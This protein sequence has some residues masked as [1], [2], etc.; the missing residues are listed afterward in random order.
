MENRTNNSV[1]RRRLQEASRPQ[2][3]RKPQ[4]T[5]RLQEEVRPRARKQSQENN[6]MNTVDRQQVLERRAKLERRKIQ[7]E[8]RRKRRVIKRIIALIVFLLFVAGIIVAVKFITYK[9]PIE[10]GNKLLN[11]QQYEEAIVEFNRAVEKEELL[12]QA[13]LGIALCNWELGNIDQVNQYFDMAYA[14]GATKTSSNVNLFLS[15]ALEAEDY[16][17]ALEYIAESLA[18]GTNTEEEKQDLLKNEIACYEKLGDWENAKT[19]ITEYVALYPEDQEA[20]KEAEF[21]ST[22]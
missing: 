7:R 12:D 8:K 20:I 15:K 17:K 1:K 19:K 16:T 10:E 22:R 9:D 21:L 2:R 3:K 11:T 18:I 13:Y 4:A 14:H 5:A 6:N